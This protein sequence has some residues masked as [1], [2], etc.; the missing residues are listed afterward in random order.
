MGETQDH[1]VSIAENRELAYIWACL[2]AWA[3]DKSRPHAACCRHIRHGVLVLSDE[4]A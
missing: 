4:Y 1:I 2:P 3:E